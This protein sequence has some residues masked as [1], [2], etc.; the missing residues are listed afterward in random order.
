VQPSLSLP[1]T[2][3]YTELNVPAELE[4]EQR[5]IDQRL[6]HDSRLADLKAGWATFLVLAVIFIFLQVLSIIMGYRTGFAA[7]EAAVAR[8]TMGRFKA[9]QH[10]LDFHERKRTAVLI[11]AQAALEHLQT[12]LL[13]RAEAKGVAPEQLQ[14]LQQAGERTF[15]VWLERQGSPTG[16]RTAAAAASVELRGRAGLQIVQAPG[17]GTN[18]ANQSDTGLVD[19]AE[20]LSWM[21]RFG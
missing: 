15:Q 9:R 8:A 4:N 10:F 7:R 20:V 11:S 14:R 1:S 3:L 13:K 16:L 17:S 19:E 12:K 2:D 6:D 18:A 5:A 21:E